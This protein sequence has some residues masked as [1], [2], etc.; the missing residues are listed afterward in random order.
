MLIGR[1]CWKLN[2][3]PKIKETQLNWVVASEKLV[4]MTL[5]VEKAMTALPLVDH[6]P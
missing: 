4:M 6:M 3:S 2:F 1:L 5:L